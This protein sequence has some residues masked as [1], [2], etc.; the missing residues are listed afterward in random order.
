VVGTPDGGCCA[1][2]RSGDIWAKKDP[3][4]GGSSS[5]RQ[6]YYI[7][8]R[9]CMFIQVRSVGNVV[10][11]CADQ[12]VWGVAMGPNW[13]LGGRGSWI[14]VCAIILLRHQLNHWISSGL[15]DG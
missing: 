13:K 14:A 10:V 12:G 6:R 3:R 2:R 7:L 4:G 8:E 15:A 11:I 9:G 5:R 1:K